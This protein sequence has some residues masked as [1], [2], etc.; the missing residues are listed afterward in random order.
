[1]PEL[2]DLLRREDSH[3][4]W[5]RGAAAVEDVVKTLTAFA[6]DL[7]GSGWGGWVLCGVEE[8]SDDQGFPLARRVGLSS[9]RFKEV[10]GKVLD[11]CRTRVSPPLVPTTEEALIPEDPSRRILIFHISASPD[12]H[13]LREE[14]GSTRIWVR[15]ADRTV[16]ARGE[17][18]RQIQQR[19]RGVPPFLQRP[20]PGSTLADL[21]LEAAKEFLSHASLPH[22]PEEYLRPGARLDAL[23]YPLILSHPQA[24]G[25]SVPVPSYLSLLLFSREPSRWIPGAFAVFSVYPGE[26]R[27]E[28]HSVRFQATSP[29]PSLIQNLLDRLQLYTGVS[30]DK[31]ASALE[32][33]QNRPRYSMKA[34]QEAIVN[35]FAHRDYESSEPVRI[36]V[37][38]DRIEIVSP[39]GFVPG[40]DPERLRRGEETPRWRNPALASFLLRLQLAQNEGQGLRTIIAETRAIAGREAR[41][42]PR[43]NDFEV[44]I[45]AFQAF[46]APPRTAGADEAAGQGLILISIGGQS[47]RPV[48]EHSLPELGLEGAEILVDF[49]LAEYVSPDVQHWEAEA[50]KIRDQVRRCVEDPRYTRIHLFYRGPVVI[51]P[52]L[53]ALVAPIKPLVVYHYEDGRYRPAYTLERRFLVGAD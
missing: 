26:G 53:G 42:A 13:N 51:A 9:S 22:P 1:M 45:P 48:V 25:E 12:L 10:Q 7:E 33:R 44:T 38:S 30:I 14:N 52:L 28:P 43:Q 29:L 39:G 27:T 23:S 6:N 18:L 16:E 46:P 49:S 37:F 40:M 11:W 17:L 5:K 41:I 20:C 34:L 8:G 35:A 2:D 4:E 50:T 3:V 32:I 36:T 19:K 21:D 15:H 47:I 31:S 24:Q